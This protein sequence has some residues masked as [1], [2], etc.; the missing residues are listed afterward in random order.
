MTRSLTVGISTNDRMLPLLLGDVPTPG[1]DLTFDRSSPIGIFR[2]ALQ[3]GAFDVTEMSFAAY[4]ILMS[5]GER[6]FVGIPVFVSRMFRHGCVFVRK[7]SEIETPEQLAGARIGIPEYQMTA[8]VWMR[9]ILD[10][11]HG[12][13]PKAVEWVRGGV[14]QPGARGEK[15]PLLLPDG[16]S[17]TDLPEGQSLNSALLAGDIDALI[18]TRMPEGKES[19][20]LRYLFP[21]VKAAERAY[22]DASGIFP[23]MH[24]LV[25][26]REI[27]DRDPSTAQALYD[28]FSAAKETSLARL[29]DIDALSVMVPWLV[30][31]IEASFAALGRDPWPYGFR[32]NRKDFNVFLRYLEKQE[33]LAGSLSPE[34]LFA[35]ELLDT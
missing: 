11:Y 16:Y 32:A 9:G 5:R 1:L 23:I 25:V 12:V 26:R 27:Y 22:Y 6:P 15:M 35:P 18:T 17:V 34:E 21:D 29:Y 28:A 8:V 33:L 10:E 3:E 4:C 30:P 2:R 19:G 24:L 7:G 20:G 13:D 14:N 31:E